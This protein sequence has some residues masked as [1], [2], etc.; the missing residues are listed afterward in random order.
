MYHREPPPTENWASISSSLQD[1]TTTGAAS[2][3]LPQPRHYPNPG[4]LGISSHSTLFNQVF[5]ADEADSTIFQH[6]SPGSLSG[7]SMH[8]LGNRVVTDR[9]FYALSCLNRM[10]ISKVTTLVEFWLARGV[11]LP[12]AGPFVTCCLESVHQWRQSLTSNPVIQTGDFGLESVS[13]VYVR[14]LLANTNKPLVMHLD[15][16]TKDFL[17]QMQGKNLRWESLGIFFTAAARAAYDTSCFAPLYSTH[18]QRH[19]LIKTLTHIGDCC[20]E[21]C[22]ELDCLND[23]Q[24]V[25]QYENFIV[26]SQVDGDQSE[27]FFSCRCTKPVRIARR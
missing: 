14:T 10:N 16:D 19:K 11:N 15:M 13:S 4:Y 6:D 2:A 25:L 20:L 17:S 24:L 18:E 26:H 1:S 21:T 23:L 8:L 22:I 9:A 3:S 7:S 12:L 27:S 5:S